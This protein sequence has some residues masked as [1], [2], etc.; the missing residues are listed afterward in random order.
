MINLLIFS[1]YLSINMLFLSFDIIEF[2]NRKVAIIIR[3]ILLIIDRII[4]IAREN[5]TE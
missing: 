5:K 4:Y 3:Y 2:N 1:L